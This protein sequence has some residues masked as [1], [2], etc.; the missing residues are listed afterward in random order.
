MAK[1]EA[2]G[3]RKGEKGGEGKRKTQICRESREAAEK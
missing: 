2:G 1:K 3:G